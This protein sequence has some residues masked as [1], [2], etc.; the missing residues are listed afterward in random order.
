MLEERKFCFLNQVAEINGG[1]DWNAPRHSRLWLYNLHYFGDL[2]AR[3]AVL[4]R[5]WHE[6]LI[7][8]WIADNLPGRGAGWEPYPTSLRIVNWIKWALAGN[9]LDEQTNQSLALQ[10]EWLS[11]HIEWHLLA[12]HVLANAK[13]LVFAGLFFRGPEASRW[14][15]KGLR[16]LEQQIGMQILD[17]GGHCELSPMYH[18]LILEDLLDLVN[19]AKTYGELETESRVWAEYALAMLEWLRAMTH[20]DGEISFFNDAAFGIAASEDALRKYAERVGIEARSGPLSIAHLVDTGYLRV[21]CEPWTILIDVGNVGPDY[22]PGHAHADSLCFELSAYG[23]RL[24][25]NGGT[26]TYQEGRERQRQRG[27]AS[28]NTVTVDGMDSSEVWAAFR[29]GRRARVRAVSLRTEADSVVIE[30]EHDG[31]RR[32]R[33]GGPLHRRNWRVANHVMQITDT[34]IGRYGVAESRLLLHPEARIE[35]RE[36]TAV[37][38]SLGGLRVTLSIQ[39]AELVVKPASWCPEFGKCVESTELSMNFLESTMV[40][41]IR[42]GEDLPGRWPATVAGC[43]WLGRG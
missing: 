29:V 14:L 22:Q 12:N 18:A 41:T 13:A 23:K 21:E 17:D 15:K 37:E 33:T 32:Q 38:L 26:S 20:P 6:R 3:D 34:L 7:K 5:E 1:I 19:L 27:T 42:S 2:V 36:R 24:F 4:R 11:R 39:G 28:H 31:Y 25:V 43:D 40:V 35:K 9:V 8:R 30:A 16:I 10:A